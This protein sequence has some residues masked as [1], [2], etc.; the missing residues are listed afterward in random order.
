MLVHP[1][2]LLPTGTLNGASA[3]WSWTFGGAVV[4]IHGPDER[5]LDREVFEEGDV[6][7]TPRRS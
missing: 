7:S 6:E 4:V 2:T 1:L 5:D 3:Y